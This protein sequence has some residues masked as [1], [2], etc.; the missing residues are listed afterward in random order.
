M[1]SYDLGLQELPFFQGLKPDEVEYN[2]P[3]VK[4]TF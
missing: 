3:L 4:T 2:G 1:R